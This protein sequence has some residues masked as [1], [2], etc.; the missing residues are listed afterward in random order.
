MELRN[1][2]IEQE[3]FKINDLQG[4]SWAFRKLREIEKKE[5]EIKAVAEQEKAL[6][7]KWLNDETESFRSERE[8]FEGLL[9]EYYLANK[10]EDKRFKLS[11]PYGKVSSRKT[12]KWNYEDEDQLKEYLKAND[13]AAIKVKEDIDKAAL[14]KIFKNGVNEET[15]EVLPF[16]NIEEVESISVKIE[17]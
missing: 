3:E 16:V 1:E 13:I 14:K 4:A 11:T 6:I 2:F 8:Y 5:T 7:D 9:K 10:R 17:E 12:K 15:G